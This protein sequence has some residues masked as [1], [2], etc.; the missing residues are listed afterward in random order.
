MLDGF[1]WAFPS[2]ST[3]RCLIT[4]NFVPPVHQYVH[5]VSLHL[6]SSQSQ[7]YPR[8]TIIAADATAITM[9]TD[10]TFYGAVNFSPLYME[11]LRSSPPSD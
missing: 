3:M 8:R 11:S 9:T 1:G 7:S 4:L 6:V 2:L 5:G 10:A